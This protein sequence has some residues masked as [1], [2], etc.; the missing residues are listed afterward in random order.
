MPD[1][2]AQRGFVE[3]AVAKRRDQR[4]PQALQQLVDR[5]WSVMVHLLWGEP[6]TGPI[7]NPV[8]TAGFSGSRGCGS[9]SRASISGPRKGTF[10]R[11]QSCARIRDHVR[12]MMARRRA[13]SRIRE[14]HR[15]ACAKWRTRKKKPG[16]REPGLRYWPREAD[17]ITFQEGLLNRPRHWRRGTNARRECSAWKHYDPRQC[18]AASRSEPH[19]SHAESGATAI[20]RRAV[21]EG[22]RCALLTTKSRNTCTRAT[23]FNS[24]G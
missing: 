20:E 2:P 21:Y 18:L 15:Q 23:V 12:M 1:Q 24:S 16:S 6:E 13:M 3:F 14:K 4:Q 17:T 11:R 5:Q 7:K 8:Q 9:L 10:F 19:V 22:Q